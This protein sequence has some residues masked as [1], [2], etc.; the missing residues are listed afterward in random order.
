M[1]VVV[2]ARPSFDG[3]AV[4][5][6]LE[7]RGVTVCTVP[8]AHAVD[9]AAEFQVRAHMCTLHERAPVFPS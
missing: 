6:A 2:L 7:S 9:D 8:C 5:A 4:A 3:A 1:Q